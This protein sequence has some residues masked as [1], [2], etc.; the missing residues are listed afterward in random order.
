M[1]RIKTKEGASL[2]IAL[3][4]TLIVAGVFLGLD[5]RGVELHWLVVAG[6]LLGTFCIVALVA[7]FIIRKY[8]AYKLKPIYS[9]VLSRDVHTTEILSEL[10]DKRVENIGEEL[11]AWADTN[12]KEI[13]RLKEAERFR[14]QYLGN[15]A[16]ELKTPIFNIQGYI[17]TLLDGGLEDEL[18]NRKYLERAEKSI[19]RL[20]NIVNDLDTISKLESSMNKLNLEKFDIVALA[21]EIAE[22]AEIE[23]DKKHIRISVKGVENLPSPFWVLADK[24]YIGQ[25]LVNLIINSIRYGK[26][27]GQT[28]IRFRD[29]LDKI[30]V[31]VEDNG[32]GIGKEDL[33]RIF[34]RFYRTDKGRSREQGG[35]GLGLAIVKHIIEAHGERISVRSEPGVGST[36]SFT[37]KK[38]N[39]Q[40]MK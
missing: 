23:A 25:V 32:L 3:L 40:D 31:E 2:W 15:V 1:I 7:L 24:H 30:L 6:V 14:K 33:P 20:I 37:L 27:G 38:V 39:L 34:E 9:I 36:F 12:D 16:H 35:T 17:S 5:L 11:T 4:A 21:K 26:E 18:I 28:R 13:A 22:Q 10:K 29:M 19:D 8:V